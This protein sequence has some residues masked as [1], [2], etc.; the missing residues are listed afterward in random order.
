MTE[1]QKFIN[2]ELLSNLVSPILCLFHCVDYLMLHF[3][4][5]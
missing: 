3:V 2:Y 1:F 4:M 5:K